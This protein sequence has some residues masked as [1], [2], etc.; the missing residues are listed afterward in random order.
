MCFEVRSLS[1]VNRHSSVYI[2]C[3]SG[4][5]SLFVIGACIE[6]SYITSYGQTRLNNLGR[7]GRSGSKGFQ[8]CIG[9]VT[10]V[11]LEKRGQEH[12]TLFKK[13]SIW[14]LLLFNQWKLETGKWM[15]VCPVLTRK[16]V[17]R[18]GNI[19]Y[20]ISFHGKKSFSTSG[21]SSFL[22][23]TKGSFCVIYTTPKHQRFF[24]AFSCRYFG[25]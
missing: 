22:S 6:D 20:V 18:R 14:T 13:P 2:T 10:F 5:F 17:F 4:S 8:Q 19:S 12:S 3:G 7:N 23:E 11:L 24:L 25:D 9:S 15:N 21:M 1:G 16:Q